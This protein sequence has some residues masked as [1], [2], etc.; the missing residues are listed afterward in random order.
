MNNT[1]SYEKE[2]SEL[3]SQVEA[4]NQIIRVQKQTINR[5]IDEYVVTK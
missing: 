3:R 5:M 1:I 2:I 4:L